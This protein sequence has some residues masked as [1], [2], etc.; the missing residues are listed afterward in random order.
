MAIIRNG[1]QALCQVR[2]EKH[3]IS[4][5]CHDVFA[6]NQNFVWVSTVLKILN[7]AEGA[8]PI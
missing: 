5:L 7:Y 2:L 8:K 1:E 4:L 6:P 3:D